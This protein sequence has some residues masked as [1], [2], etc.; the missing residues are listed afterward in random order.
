MTTKPQVPFFR[1]DLRAAEI[2]EVVATLES[3][4]LTTGARVRSFE[5]RFAA[6]LGARHAIA[7]NSCTAAMHLAVVALDLRPGD[8]VLVPTMTFAA[9]AEVV[10][11]C[12]ATPI[13]VDCDPATLHMDL[14]DAERKLERYT[15][16]ELPVAR[17]G[18]IVGA[19]PVHV[20]G[21]MMLIDALTDLAERHDLWLV[22]DAAHAY[23]AATETREGVR[24]C[25]ENTADATCFS[26]Y[27]NKTITTGEGGMLAT[28][29]D[30]LAER[31]R[32][33]ALHGLS[34][35]AWERYDTPVAG[36][37]PRWDYRIVEA[38][39]KYNLTDVAAAI[40]LGQLDRAE[41]MR[42]DR[43]RLARRYD[44]AFAECAALETPPWPETGQ[45]A[46][47]LYPIRLHLDQLKIDRNR[48][49]EGLAERGVGFSV[50]WRPLHLH[51]YYEEFGWRER[52]LPQATATW[53][54]LVSLPLFPTMTNDEQDYVVDVVRDLLRRNRR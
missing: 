18:S 23:P 21:S 54:R 22:E 52:D 53:L 5:E 4:W 49:V 34:T 47:H 9:T 39:Y 27:A 43:E 8:A 17:E 25:G 36:K 20:G 45:H 40:G 42:E 51:P 12:G 24:R 11:Y 26:F 33:L 19:L 50:H 1:P 44:E 35:D 30:D 10:R 38:G 37:G 7:V 41:A 15:A 28:A 32:R 3:G 29:R 14:E 31:A 6:S 48:F 16:G 2:D 46:W 13:L